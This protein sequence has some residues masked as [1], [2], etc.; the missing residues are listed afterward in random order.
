MFFQANIHIQHLIQCH[1]TLLLL[2][3]KKENKTKSINKEKLDLM[4][5]NPEQNKINTKEVQIDDK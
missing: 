4:R 5:I 2:N 3:K 1:Q